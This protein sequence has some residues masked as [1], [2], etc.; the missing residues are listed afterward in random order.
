MRS[1]KNDNEACLMPR[2]WYILCKVYNVCTYVIAFIIVYAALILIKSIKQA[3]RRMSKKRWILETETVGIGSACS[4]YFSRL[5]NEGTCKR[6]G[7]FRY[8]WRNRQQ[9]VQ[10]ECPRHW[11]PC[12]TS[13]FE[14]GRIPLSHNWPSGVIRMGSQVWKWKSWKNFW[15]KW[16]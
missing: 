15:T 14:V 4:G 1:E 13:I 3:T 11:N 5:A 12:V 16:V 6:D 7:T 9:I 8:N 2:S 10:F